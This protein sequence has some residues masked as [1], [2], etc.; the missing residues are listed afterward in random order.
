M[1]N[2]TSGKLVALLLVGLVVGAGIGYLLGGQPYAGWYSPEEYQAAAA[3]EI[4]AG[5][6]ALAAAEAEAAAALAAAE[7]EAAAALTAA[8]AAAAAAA[9]AATAAAAPSTLP[10]Y[11]APT[12]FFGTTGDQPAGDRC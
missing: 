11:H 1:S 6:A 12:P 10:T 2:Q 3:A 7:A 8:E 4:A 5:A 9:A